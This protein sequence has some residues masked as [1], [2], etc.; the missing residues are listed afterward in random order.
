MNIL[1]YNYHEENES[2]TIEFAIDEDTDLYYRVLKFEC[3]DIDYYSPDYTRKQNLGE[4]DDDYILDL[5]TRY[6]NENELPEQ[7]LL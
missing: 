1:G 5:L 6:L 4:I 7:E 3:W 2:L